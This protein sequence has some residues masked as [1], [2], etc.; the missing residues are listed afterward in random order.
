ML[1]YYR[2]YLDKDNVI[3]KD[4]TINLGKNPVAE[5]F[6]GGTQVDPVY[7]RYVFSFDESYL[8]N[9]Y[10]NCF[11]GDLT[12]TSH[13]LKLKPTWYFGDN[14]D[15]CSAS[16]YTLCISKINQH[17]VEGCG[18]LYDCK[19]GCEQLLPLKCNASHSASNWFMANSEDEWE[20]E[21]VIDNLSGDTIQCVSIDCEN[22]LNDFIE[23]DLT[24][25]INNMLSGGA[26]NFGYV[27]HLSANFENFPEN[28]TKYVGFYTK[29]TDTFFQPFIETKYDHV[30]ED[31]R[32]D[33]ILNKENRIYLHT[34]K[35]NDGIILDQAPS[36]EI[37]N[38][39]ETLIYSG[40][41][42]CV[43]K[44]IYE[45]SVQVS[46]TAEDCQGLYEDKWKD[47]AYM[48]A[49]IGEHVDQIEPKN[50]SEVFS[51]N[52]DVYESPKYGFKFRGI[53]QNE[54]ITK[55]EIRKIF[56][57]LYEAYSL[58]KKTSLDKVFYKLYVKQGQHELTIIDWS[59]ANLS[60]CDNWF[61]LDTSWM[62]EQFYYVSIKVE[63]NEE[64]SLYN[65]V[66]KFSVQ[67]G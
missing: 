66:V 2:T 15:L 41:S 6:Y 36:V 47:M 18:Y 49:S 12:K 61:Y 60:L 54:I 28:Q 53:K 67:N 57:D 20:Q 65:D 25:E 5:L 59:K 64:I 23:F 51:F 13:I 63:K 35:N 40:S 16:S 55:G 9:L 7:S 30:I 24:D 48:S 14:E 10:Q 19:G 22:E 11:L 44:G 29:D 52:Q 39:N 42:Q 1:Y 56:V 62:V 32:Y 43:S 26:D 31:D 17:W 21:G 8:K 4:S 33:F 27:I 34:F 38:N 46:G 58:N 50:F 37:Y 3:V 45:A